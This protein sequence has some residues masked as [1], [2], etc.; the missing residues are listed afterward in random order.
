M[1]DNNRKW[2]CSEGYIWNFNQWRQDAYYLSTVI[3]NDGKR[4]EIKIE[5][6]EKGYYLLIINVPEYDPI[7]NKIGKVDPMY[8]DLR[9]L[10]PCSRRGEKN[11]NQA[12][13]MMEDVAR[14]SV[15]MMEEDK[16]F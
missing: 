14:E 10:V 7:T 11:F 9:L 4:E 8:S 5:A 15:E 1:A 6:D 16:K 3:F 12:V 13:S 2:D